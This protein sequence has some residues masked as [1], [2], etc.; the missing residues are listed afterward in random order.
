MKIELNLTGEEV[1]HLLSFACLINND[2][3]V[4]VLEDASY[5]LNYVDG[6]IVEP[7]AEET[8]DVIFWKIFDQLRPLPMFD[9]YNDEWPILHESVT[10]R[11]NS[12]YKEGRF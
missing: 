9:K 10:K 12:D 5:D 2:D 6:A 11:V 4:N 7:H 3:I 1:Q 8:I